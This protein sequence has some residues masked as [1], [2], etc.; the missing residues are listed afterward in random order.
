MPTKIDK[1][2][3]TNFSALT[4][5]YG[6]DNLKKIDKAVAA[7]IAADK[8]RG[9]IAEYVGL[10]NAAAMKK[11][12]ATPVTSAS[13]RKQNKAAIDGIYKALAP[14]YI[15]ILGS[16]D[17]VPH[18]DMRN[19]MYSPDPDG[20]PDRFAF[21]DLPYACEKPYGQRP[22]DFIGP[23]RVIGRL[24]DLTGINDPTYLIDLLETATSYSSTTA[25][26]YHDYLGITAEVWK[27][28]TEQSLERIF[29]ETKSL[30]SVPP[31]KDSWSKSLIARKVLFVNCHGNFNTPYFSGQS[32]ADEDDYP[33]ALRASFV[34]GKIT[35]GTLAAIE[36]CY[37]GQLY[38]PKFAKGQAGVCNTYLENKAYGFFASTT[39]AYG[40][41]SGNGQADL[42]C[43]YFLR[44]V[45]AGA[46]I[47]RAALE[48]RQ[49]FARTTSMG[50][51]MNIKTLAQF[52]LYGDPSCSPVKMLDPKGPQPKTPAKGVPCSTVDRVDRSSRRRALF[53]EGASITATRSTSRESKKPPSKSIKAALQNKARELGV[54]GA[55]TKS[56]IVEA[57]KKIK[58]MPKM[59]IDD[60]LIPSGYHVLLGRER[61]NG[62]MSKS[63]NKKMR[64]TPP[65]VTQI[66]AL[67]AKEVDGKVVSVTKLYSK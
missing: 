21:G 31:R 52:N 13:N 47:G 42:I 33:D 5:K 63:K 37:G 22:Q 14:D 50:N 4:E 40:P 60:E 9:L 20:D 53:I 65:P 66:V 45:L 28:S 29:G 6:K 25:D 32:A 11:V 18:Q 16:I 35:E 44:S 58:G 49:K 23:T 36:C 19:P 46:S 51:P 34:N 43:Q 1:V 55:A 15:M 67:V 2:I 8:N 48:A 64:A 56:F 24:P 10:D 54:I 39:I 26:A 62:K 38:N 30:N 61:I 12:G 59:M 57:P 7:L 27:S 41:S 17:V 3:V